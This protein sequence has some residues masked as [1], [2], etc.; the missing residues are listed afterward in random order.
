MAPHCGSIATEKTGTDVDQEDVDWPLAN[1][2]PWDKVTDARRSSSSSPSFHAF[3]FVFFVLQSTLPRRPTPQT[4]QD[5]PPFSVSHID[6]AL[7]LCSPAQ[8]IRT[9]ATPEVSPLF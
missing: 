1:Q 2:A 7:S 6:W 5:L 8:E 3:L 4:H 9:I